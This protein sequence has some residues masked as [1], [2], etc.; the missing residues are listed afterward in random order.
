MSLKSSFQIDFN[1]LLYSN[2]FYC[3]YR[4]IDKTNK[5]PIIIKNIKFNDDDFDEKIINNEIKNIEL[6]NLS[7]NSHHYINHY[8]E[9]HNLFIIY[10]NYE[11]NLNNFINN[12][13]FSIEEIQDIISQLNNSFKILYDKNL[14]HLNINSYNILIKK[15]NDKNIYLLSDFWFQNIKQ[16][17][18]INENDD[19]ISVAPEIKLNSSNNLNKADLW[20]IGI[21]LYNLYFNKSPF[22][23]DEEYLNFIS[24]N[25]KLKLNSNN[26]DLNDLIENLLISDSNKRI[27]WEDYFDHNFFKNGFSRT[28]YDNYKI[29]YEGYFKDNKKYK[30]KEYDLYGN[31]EF[32]GEYDNNENRWNGKVKEY[33]EFGDLK[34]E[35]EYFNGNKIENK[36]YQKDNIKFDDENKNS[37]LIQ[38][39]KESNNLNKEIILDNNNNNK[40]GFEKEN[41]NNKIIFEGENKVNKKLKE[42]ECDDNKNL[43]NESEYKDDLK[44][45]EKDYKINSINL[46]E[47]NEK[48]YYGTTI[49]E[50][51]NILIK[52]ISK[53]K[54]N[55]KLIKKYL[56]IYKLLISEIKFEIFIELFNYEDNYFIVI[57]NYK[58][59][60]KNLIDEFKVKLPNELI[61][62]IIIIFY[63]I[64]KFFDYKKLILNFLNPENFLYD[65]NSLDKKFI[66][67]FNYFL[68]K[69]LFDY[70]EPKLIMKNEKKYDYN[71]P[72]LYV[73]EN[74]NI[75]N[76][77]NVWSLGILIYEMLFH[78]LPDINYIKQ[79]NENDILSNLIIKM[80]EIDPEKR[81]SFKYILEIPFFN[82]IINDN[83]KKVDFNLNILLLGEYD[84]GRYCII[85]SF[86]YDSPILIKYSNIFQ[87]FEKKIIYKNNLKINVIMWSFYSSERFRRLSRLCFKNK[88]AVI[89]VYDN[90]YSLYKLDY[91]YNEEDLNGKIV[92]ICR[93][94][95]DLYNIS[96]I[97]KTHIEKFCLEKK[98]DFYFKTSCKTYEGIEE[99]FNTIIDC[100]LK[101]HN[102]KENTI[103]ENNEIK[104]ENKIK[105][106]NKN[107]KNKKCIII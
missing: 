54:Y 4:G 43:I 85:K 13:K 82:Q 8:I 90:E 107:N 51:K 95:I 21:L 7:F 3:I 77:I 70:K 15:E 6:L 76:K 1:N 61:Y 29:K 67:N 52:E 84:E 59:N 11:Y 78:Q 47:H 91:Y 9:D 89:L 37:K 81:I 18:L 97:E 99:M 93:N 80:L 55:I 50:K 34:F 12:K 25:E 72:E 20:S 100:Y 75:T 24:K 44:I 49:D 45:F 65:E 5:N 105:N 102:I 26:E 42:K 10:E 92:G 62:K 32:E 66:L 46:N 19:L 35:G 22:Q 40:S 14:F 58:K 68:D 53:Y 60:L 63:N 64:I 71:A 74:K 69:C 103:K 41:N 23:N 94:K 96:L 16:K 104:I 98:I 83:N 30:G 87:V 38:L 31:L 57:E 73:S 106:K 39:E 2:K 33:N 36:S 86:V 88:D 79:L 101:K 28:Y 17:Y 27:S 48:I 56:E